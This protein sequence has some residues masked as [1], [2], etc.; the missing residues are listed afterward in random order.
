MK[1]AILFVGLW[2]GV[3]AMLFGGV[4]SVAQASGGIVLTDDSAVSVAL[5][6]GGLTVTAAVTYKLTRFMG[7]L[8]ATIDRI[9]VLEG[10]QKKT[11]AALACRRSGDRQ[12]E[13]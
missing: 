3:S 11:D 6:L 12:N 2:T 13:T 1:V 8:D 7:K 4:S 10:K 5:F 9:V